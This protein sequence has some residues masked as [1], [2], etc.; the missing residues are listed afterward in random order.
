MPNNHVLPDIESFDLKPG[1][2]LARKY[3][4]GELLGRGWE[5]E[6]YHVTED[7]T[8]VERAAKIFFP[9]RNPG[10]KTSNF[11]ARKL[12]KLRDC[13]ILIQYHTHESFR[14]RGQE[15]P[16]MVSE[17]VQ[18]ELLTDFLD[19]QRGKR[20]HPFEALVLLHALA[21]GVEQIHAMR[22]YHGDLHS[23]NI[24]VNR[25]GI[26]FE[27]KLVDMYHWGRP[28][29]QHFLDDLCAL[30]RCFYDALGGAARYSKQAAELKS[31]CCGLKRSLIT[32]KFRSVTA[33]RLHLETMTW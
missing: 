10:N 24:I 13:S 32:R 6:V 12:D 28:T 11:Y 8:G 25:R 26:G 3:F 2:L 7:R 14:Y 23:D 22:E 17:Y 21:K 4:V 1:R 16:F 19:R 15:I 33:L 29:Q 20:L 9:K 5:G 18:G 27:I 31:I 30:V